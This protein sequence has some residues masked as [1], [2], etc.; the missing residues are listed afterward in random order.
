RKALF[1]VTARHLVQERGQDSRARGTDRMSEGNGAA[2]DIDDRRVPT[3]VLVDRER[4]GREGF[5][6]FHQLEVLDG[7]SRLFASAALMMTRA[8]AP[9]LMPEA[10]AAVTVPSLEKAGRS[11]AMAS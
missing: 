11:F 10:L 8:A 2:V 5:I 1:C 9:S 7:P 6:G 4:L 3:E